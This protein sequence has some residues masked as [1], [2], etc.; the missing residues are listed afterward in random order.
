MALDPAEAESA[1]RAATDKE[2]YN[3][4]WSIEAKWIYAKIRER[5]ITLHTTPSRTSSEFDHVMVC[6]APIR[7]MC[8]RILMPTPL[9]QPPT[10]RSSLMTPT[11]ASLLP[12][13]HSSA[14]HVF[15]RF[16]IIP[17]IEVLL[18]DVKGRGYEIPT[19]WNG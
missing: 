4:E 2:M 15:R 12:P 6:L 11:S 14:Y 13:Q 19:I 5:V 3:Q 9:L 17:L 10:P 18:R 1:A 7:R 8:S 16:Q